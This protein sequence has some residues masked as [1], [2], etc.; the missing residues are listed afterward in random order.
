MDP[1][2]TRPTTS[3]VLDIPPSV[4]ESYVASLPVLDLDTLI[5]PAATRC[6]YCHGP[7]DHTDIGMHASDM[8]IHNADDLPLGW[9]CFDCSELIDVIIG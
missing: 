1:L 7:L 6:I 2:I 4:V 8:L 5:E 9:S 3:A